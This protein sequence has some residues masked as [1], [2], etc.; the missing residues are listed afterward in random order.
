MSN[1][2]AIQLLILY[3]CELIKNMQL[4]IRIFPEICKNFEVGIHY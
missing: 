3:F 4:L 1:V 2:I